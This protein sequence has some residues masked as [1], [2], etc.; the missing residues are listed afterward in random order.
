MPLISWPP[1]VQRFARGKTWWGII[2]QTPAQVFRY[3]FSRQ[4]IVGWV[5]LY[6]AYQ[7]F[8]VGHWQLV[9][10]QRMERWKRNYRADL[11]MQE[12]D[13]WT[14]KANRDGMRNFIAEQ[15][16]AHG[17]F[18]A[19]AKAFADK[20][21]TQVPTFVVDDV[22]LDFTLKRVGVPVPGGD[23]PEFLWDGTPFT[24]KKPVT[25]PDGKRPLPQPPKYY[26]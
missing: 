11:H 20:T 2:S 17:S 12:N 16:K 22:V 6:C 19:A 24:T 25:T 10:D 3:S 23:E 18:E 1:V 5:G 8:W 26:I 13:V 7:Y 9:K 15:V 14:T 4:P 21:G